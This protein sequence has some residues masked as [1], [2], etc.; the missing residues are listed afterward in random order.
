MRSFG[1]VRRKPRDMGQHM[2][3]SPNK[4]VFGAPNTS[5]VFGIAYLSP[6]LCVVSGFL[7][8]ARAHAQEESRE[9]GKLPIPPRSPHITKNA[10]RPELQELSG[11]HNFDSSRPDWCGFQQA[12]NQSLLCSNRD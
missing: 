11:L 2:P 8:F 6:G 3:R 7:R 10:A 12:R 9:A 4:T 5:S 1:S